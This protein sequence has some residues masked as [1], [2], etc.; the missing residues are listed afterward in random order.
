MLIESARGTKGRGF[1]AA[2]MEVGRWLEWESQVT[3]ELG[4]GGQRGLCQARDAS[5][6]RVSWVQAVLSCSVLG[7]SDPAGTLGRVSVLGQEPLVASA[8]VWA[9]QLLKEGTVLTP[10]SILPI[11][12]SSRKRTPHAT[13]PPEV[14]APTTPDALLSL[15]LT[16]PQTVSHVGWRWDGEPSSRLRCRPPE[17]ASPPAFS[18][19]LLLA[20]PSS[21]PPPDGLPCPPAPSSI[22]G[23]VCRRKNSFHIHWHLTKNH[24][25]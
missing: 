23:T 25:L 7:R 2:W 18:A 14:N 19:C 4:L 24:H 15:A 17:G 20:F 1:P 21:L 9:G 11:P 6:C 3:L 22:S 12:A 13:S 8:L 16:F 5:P 10:T